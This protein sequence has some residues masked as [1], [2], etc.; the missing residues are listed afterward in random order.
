MNIYIKKR[1]AQIIIC[2]I[3]L[4]RC[5][6]IETIRTEYANWDYIIN[7]SE[8]EKGWFPPL[9]NE[10]L[11]FNK[12]IYNIIIIN[13]PSTMNV[14]GKLNYHDNIFENL[15][16]QQNQYIDNIIVNNRDKR[17]MKRLGFDNENIEIYFNQNQIQYRMTWHYF[18]DTNDKTL[19]F[20]SL[21]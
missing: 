4:C 1:I 11:S 17:I 12:N 16:D 21:R 10:N 7:A 15:H 3:M 6:N 5:D 13:D 20:I 18:I 2:T 8:N 14:W 19:Y 9:F